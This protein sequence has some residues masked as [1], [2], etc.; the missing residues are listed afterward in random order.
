MGTHGKEQPMKWKKVSPEMC[1]ILDEALKG[2][3]CDKRQM[4]GC[5]AYFVNNNMFAGVHQDSIILRLSEENRKKIAE[6]T[7]EVG[8]FEP[9]EGRPMKEYVAVPEPFASDRREFM[10]WLDRAYEYAR[11]L[12]PKEKKEKKK[13]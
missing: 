4:F 13:G 7:D 5:P 12:P 10:K 1:A 6:V 2:Y 3:A 11:A 8:P 9:M